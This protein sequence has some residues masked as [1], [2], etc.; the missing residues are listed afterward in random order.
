MYALDSLV[1]YLFNDDKNIDSQK[2]KFS[3]SFYHFDDNAIK[4]WRNGVFPYHWE[5]ILKEKE[6]ADTKY[7]H[8]SLNNPKCSNDDYE[9]AKKIY[10][11]FKLENI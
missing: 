3:S 7:V 8:N 11:C 5:E 6:L 1:N 2:Q 4:L 10:D 9:Y